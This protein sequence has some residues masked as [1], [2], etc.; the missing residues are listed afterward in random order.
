MDHLAWAGKASGWA[1]SFPSG[2]LIVAAIGPLSAPEPAILL[3]P[4]ER[5]CVAFLRSH[6]WA[7]DEDPWAINLGDQWAI[8][9]D[10]NA[11]AGEAN[12]TGNLIVSATTMAVVF[13]SQVEGRSPVARDLNT[14]SVTEGR[15]LIF[16]RWDLWASRAD[17]G[18]RP[19]ATLGAH[20][21]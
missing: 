15:G 5:Q 11:P 8:E 18:R 21:E 13:P 17:L 20:Q 1:S 2:S 19:L 10:L 14:G 7:P 16:S 9:P 12:K 4:K 6:I 3:R